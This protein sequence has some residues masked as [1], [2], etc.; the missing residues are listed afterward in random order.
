MRS[1]MAGLIVVGV[2]AACQPR[3]VHAPGTIELIDLTDDF[4]DFHDLTAHLKAEDR[5]NT[6]ERFDKLFPGFYDAGRISYFTSAQY[7]TAIR[8][9]IDRFPDCR[10]RYENRA[11][12]LARDIHDAYADFARRFPDFEMRNPVYMLCSMRW[13]R[14][15]RA[16]SR[17][18][19]L[20]APF[21]VARSRACPDSWTHEGLERPG[22]VRP[23]PGTRRGRRLSGGRHDGRS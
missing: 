9:F 3:R 22:G 13:L 15:R 16:W 21:V 4:A 8:H 7:E 17:F 10:T 12:R 11:R 23:P 19:R 1:I 14:P 6:R 20:F 5:V 18:S 2:L